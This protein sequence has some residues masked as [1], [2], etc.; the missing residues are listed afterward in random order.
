MFSVNNGILSL[1]RG[2]DAYLYVGAT[3]GESE[4]LEV[5]VFKEQLCST[6]LFFR[7]Q[8]PDGS[9]LI[10]TSDT[11]SL[12]IGTYW[13]QVVKISG[14][15]ETVVSGPAELRVMAEVNY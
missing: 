6:L 8:L 5:R 4:K 10:N 1:T 13:Y 12:A 7:E 3:L 2:D 9:F 15:S 11:E 14:G